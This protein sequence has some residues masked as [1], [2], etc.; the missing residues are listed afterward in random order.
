MDSGLHGRA[1]AASTL[2]PGRVVVL[3]TD[4]CDAV[5][6]C[7]VEMSN[8]QDPSSTVLAFH[9]STVG[10]LR[11]VPMFRYVHAMSCQCQP[12]CLSPACYG[13][14]VAPC[15]SLAVTARVVH[16]PC[17]GRHAKTDFCDAMGLSHVATTILLGLSRTDLALPH[18]LMG[19]LRAVPVF[20]HVRATSSSCQSG[21]LSQHAMAPW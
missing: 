1:M 20:M 7:H 16:S 10:F 14:F 17:C 5:G 8:L 13:R 4:V 15:L 3:Q 9:H 11:A 2:S 21:L 12:V 6:L 19:V 18:R